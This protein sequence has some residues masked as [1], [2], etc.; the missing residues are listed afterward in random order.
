MRA[1]IIKEHGDLDQLIDTEVPEPKIGADEVL[2]KVKA[3]ALNHLD[4]WTRLGI[5]GIQ[6]PMPH[7]LG[8]DISGEIAQIGKNVKPKL[9]IGRQV[10]VAPGL[11]PK[12]DP[13]AGSDW[14][15]LS[16]DFKIIGFQVDGGYA[17]YVKVPAWNVI[18]V[19]TKLS[20]EEWAAFPLVFL[21]AWHM[22]VTRA[23]LQRGETV[24]IHSAGSGVGMAGIQIAKY[25]GA[26]V[27]STVG[28][29]KKIKPAQKIG[30]NHVINYQKKEF[31]REVRAITKGKG[32]DVVLEHIGP[33][34]FSKSLTCLKKKGRL[35]TC[36]V[37]SGSAIEL[38]L[39]FFYARQL[40][41]QGC[42]MGGIS[43]LRK[44][45]HLAEAGKLKP[46]IDQIFP[47][48]D[49]R[50]AQER[51]LERKNFGKIILVP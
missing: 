48:K 50:A 20:S 8:C 16:N 42:Y 38:D 10:I 40:S 6:I 26:H 14:E 24:L 30:A 12:N 3:C 11:V 22:L 41:I 29:D 5:P 31:D 15:S 51:M 17:E 23:D 37:T 33:Q 34:T 49:A 39:R 18:P 44:V 1:T 7:I 25:L 46:V 45:V 13:L 43:E 21:T 9:K 2:V 36:G 47:L 35:V 27:I 19:S 4:I 32:V 28:N